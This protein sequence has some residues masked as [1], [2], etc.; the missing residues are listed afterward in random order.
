[1]A[2][3]FVILGCVIPGPAKPEPGIHNPDTHRIIPA[4][5]PGFRARRNAPPRN[6]AAEPDSVGTARKV[7]AFH[8]LC[9]TRLCPPYELGRNML[10]HHCF[11][12]TFSEEM[13]IT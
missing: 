4:G 7:L 11:G 13:S 1:M 10:Q 3:L 12:P 9:A 2:S 8:M 6:D 5:G